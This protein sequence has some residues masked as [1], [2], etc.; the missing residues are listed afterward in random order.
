MDDLRNRYQRDADRIVH[1]KSFRRLMHKTQV[2]LMPEG[3]HYRTRMTHAL[4]VS[5]IA[6]TMARA[7]S[8]DE[9]LTEA[10]ALGHDL[11][12]PPF[13]HAG[14]RALDTVIPF[15]HNTQSLRV[16]ERLE[17]DGAGLNL[18]DEVREGILHHSGQVPSQTQ[19]GM[20][21][22]YA[23]RIAYLS[24]DMDDAVRG[25]LLSLTDVPAALR[26]ELGDTP[27]DRINTLVNDL[28]A[29]SRAAGQ[30]RLSKTRGEAM[31]ELRTFM[32]D[33]VYFNP[34][35]KGEETKVPECIGRLFEHFLRRYDD[36]PETL[37]RIAEEDG[38]GHERAV[39]D[40]IAGM[41]DRFFETKCV[42]TFIPQGWK[43]V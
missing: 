10:I 16:V 34:N 15:S 7:L 40:Y 38:D 22:R 33:N 8:L 29:E 11:G 24:H 35:A 20:L 9:D 30:V 12:H 26:K 4:E 6:R 37:R 14:E 42:E 25:G 27:K 2:F 23:D 28:V 41:T 3:D 32:Y 18:S 17:K 13:G 5:R 1:S 19:E 21:V 39:C 43:V 36:V 31:D